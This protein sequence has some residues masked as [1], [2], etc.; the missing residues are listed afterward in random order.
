MS[1]IIDRSIEEEMKTA[2]L[3]YA[4]SVIVS[5]ALPDVRDGL[6]PVHRRI[7]FAMNEM[8][9]TTDRRYKKSARIVG[10]VLGKYH[11]HGEAAVYNTL[12]RLGQDFS[13]RYRVI[14]GQG[15]YG[16]VDGDMPASM[17]YTEARMTGFGMEFLKDIKKD[18]V[19]VQLNFDDSL[20]EPVVLPAGVP[21]LLVNGSTGIA[22]GMA[23]NIPPHNLREVIDGLIYLL[24]HRE[25]S[26]V[27]LLKYVK[28]PDFPTYGM[29][30]GSGGIREMY[31][32]GRG[33]VRVRARVDFEELSGGREALVIKELPYQVNKAELLTK[34][35][36]LVKD[37]KIEGVGDIRDESNR[38]G[39]RAV[40][41]LKRGSHGQV[42]LNQLYAHT[43]MQIVFGM[44]MLVLVKNQ[45][46][47]LNLKEVME[48]YIRHRQEII[49]RRTKYDLRR[50]EARLHIVIG[51]LK[52]LEHISEIIR[53]IRASRDVGEA[54][55]GL[56]RGY[57]LS[58]KQAQA[59]LD[60]RLQ[61]LTG[62]EG[63]KLESERAELEELIGGYRALL[64]QEEKQYG[65][66]KEEFQEIRTRY[67]DDRRTEIVEDIGDIEIEDLIIDEDNVITM[68]YGGYIKRLAVTIYKKQKRGGVGVS[69]AG[70]M[71]KQD[72]LIEHLFVASTHDYMIFFSNIGRVF[73]VRVHEINEGSRISRGRHIKLLLQLDEDEMIKAILPVRQFDDRPIVLV[74]KQGVIKRCCLRDFS[75]AKVRGIK[76]MNLD[77]GDLLVSVVLSDGE[78]DIMLCTKN[79]K[80]LRLQEL[81]VRT[82]GRIA[83]GV[84]G[85]RLKGEDEVIGVVKVT[86]EK[87]LLMISKNGYGKRL[88]FSNMQVHRR[89]TEGQKYF[90]V[91]Q[92]TGDVVGVQVVGDN[93]ELLVITS[94]GMVNKI[95]VKDIKKYGRLASGVR[96]VNVKENDFVVGLSSIRGD[97][98]EELD[99][100]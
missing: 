70:G 15:N 100:N 6:K 79:G 97:S 58:E 49:I 91:N 42:V 13:M 43:S 57:D 62:L 26:V 74:T 32:K 67:G 23:T 18:T 68:S 30:Y 75:R 51:L 50:A 5:R 28:G 92:K 41:E 71:V 27:D 33:K 96:V 88:S 53:L 1:D 8:G 81:E 66:M 93:D 3:T 90:G 37:K 86:E 16:S 80:A 85:I 44:I 87:K 94:L 52:A 35:A 78:G 73:F 36:H 54:R 31:E 56:M 34:I 46:K 60:M 12:V 89:G 95:G 14:D 45:P 25:A 69:G 17:R 7:L 9:L 84:R 64:E 24:D 63:E 19:D 22:V 61:R 4:M 77:E 10:E 65:V 20:E 38:E 98:E 59:I 21:N 40:I 76:G 83:R 99:K 55:E 39:M 11:P 48:H 2:Y 72:D 82:M 47:V 29:I